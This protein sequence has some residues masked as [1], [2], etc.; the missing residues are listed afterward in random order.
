MSKNNAYDI[1]FLDM[2]IDDMNGLELG[3]RIREYDEEVVII[4]VTAYADYTG[5]AYEIFAFNYILKPVNPLFFEKVMN[6][7]TDSIM[8]KRAVLNQHFF[9][10]NEGYQKHKIFYNEF[11][12]AEK[13]GKRIF[14][15]LTQQRLI[16]PVM[17]LNA[18]EE[19]LDPKYIIRCHKTFLINK[20]KIK[21]YETHFLEME[22]FDQLIPVGRKYK[23]SVGKMVLEMI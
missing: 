18:L 11:I 7:A 21:S 15:N 3:K 22:G 4:Y 6:R 2:E 17:T 1:I 20:Y 5:K 16:L 23:E 19:T 8:I 12:V 10:I 9:M 14:L 13:K